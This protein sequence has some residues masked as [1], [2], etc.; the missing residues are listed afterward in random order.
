[1]FH[2]PLVEVGWVLP[3]TNHWWPVVSDYSAGDS[4]KIQKEWSSLNFYFPPEEFQ[5]GTRV[6]VLEK[7]LLSCTLWKFY[8]IDLISQNASS[9][10]SAKAWRK[11]GD[12]SS[13]QVTPL[14]KKQLFSV[15]KYNT[16]R[17]LSHLLVFYL[18][19]VNFG[20]MIRAKDTGIYDTGKINNESPLTK[21]VL[22]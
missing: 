13:S 14:K 8:C 19:C 7:Y 11:R 2:L 1:M 20:T 10:G 15:L 4:L 6:C 21:F 17:V 9:N 22:Q 5:A 3:E 18:W 12:I 16:H